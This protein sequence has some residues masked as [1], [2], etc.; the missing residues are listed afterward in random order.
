MY[1]GIFAEFP[2]NLPKVKSRGD[3]VAHTPFSKKEV[4]VAKGKLKKSAPGCDGLKR[5]DIR[6]I[7]EDDLVALLNIVWGLKLIP[8]VWRQNRT[9]LI[10]KSD[11]P[12]GVNP[13]NWRPITIS[14]L[15]YRLMHKI[16]AKRLESDLKLHS[17]QRRFTQTD[18]I[19]ANL[20]ILDT[21]IREHRGEG[22]SMFMVSVDLAK[23]FDRVSKESILYRLA[24]EGVD[25]DTIE[26]IRSAYDGMT[27][28]L[29]C[30][31]Q[32]SQPLSVKRGIRQGDPT[33]GA[34]FNLVMD[35]VIR[36]FKSEDG[37]KVGD[38]RV[39]ALAFADDLVVLSESEE[40]MRQHLAKLEDFLHEH[41]MEV[42]VGKCKALQIQRIPGTKR[43]AVRKEPMFKICGSTV[44]TLSTESQLGYLGHEFGHVGTLAPNP[45]RL[46]SMLKS[47]QGAALKP[48]Q[49]MLMLNRYLIPR[50]MHHYQN[51]R[52]TA[53]HLEHVDRLV[54]T[55]VKATLHLPV[56]TPNAYLYAKMRDGGLSVP[57]M[58][59]Q[60][61]VVYRRRL[62]KLR[63][64]G[65][66]Q[67]KSVLNSETTRKLLKR[68]D[69][70][71]G[72]VGP[73]RNDSKEYWRAQLEKC[74]LCG[75]SKFQGKQ[76]SHWVENPPPYWS[77]EDYAKA[78]QL[79][80][81]LLPTRGAPYVSSESGRCR[82][83]ACEQ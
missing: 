59:H 32:R 3:K 37:V 18:G 15:M 10:P 6:N 21:A 7:P 36:K 46:E 47:L 28:T 17:A 71:C 70:I 27:T 12:D 68:L 30:N 13:G 72:P 53:K 55:F 45:T 61:G 74:A 34:L 67:V 57:C 65:D 83:N 75:I 19:M 44:A 48:Q 52:V 51:P 29:E 50:I 49:K 76:T 66:E 2:L 1:S 22:R 80:I 14:S 23:A 69:V 31:G 26:Y 73:R 82:S 58:R 77:G 63:M 35:D 25:K 5:E 4:V 38:A 9:V 20:T 62:A 41:G 33:S 56:T 16:V 60:V 11:P 24:V 42:N 78:I 81:G 64:Q 8:S 43:A 54:R 79:R 40:G 39:C